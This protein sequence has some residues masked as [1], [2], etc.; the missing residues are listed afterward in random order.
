MAH[1]WSSTS[2]N[3]AIMV[4]LVSFNLLRNEPAGRNYPHEGNTGAP[5]R[6]SGEMGWEVRDTS[7]PIH[8]CINN[9]SLL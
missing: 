7:A 8:K 2:S 9:L 1:S 6:A 5:D 3:L 4:S